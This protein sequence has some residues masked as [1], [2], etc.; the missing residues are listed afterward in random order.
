[1]D[2]LALRSEALDLFKGA[3][4]QITPTPEDREKLA[5]WTLGYGE[6]LIS[7]EKDKAQGYLDAIQLKAA[8][9]A[10]KAEN[11]QEKFIYDALMSAG[12]IGIALL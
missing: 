12:R 9:Y 7:G 8:Q 5:D 10:I 2:T 6:A 11:A 4:K 1:M 3:I